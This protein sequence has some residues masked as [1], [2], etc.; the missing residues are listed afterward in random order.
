M[1]MTVKT[2]TITTDAYNSIKNMKNPGESFSQLF[3]RI[4]KKKMKVKDLIGA[5]KLSDEEYRALKK[6]TKKLRKKASKDMEERLK[7]CTF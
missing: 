1:F 3:L 7:R 6:H 5:V 2:L 4:S